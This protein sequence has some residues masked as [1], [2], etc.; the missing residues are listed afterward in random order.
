[1]APQQTTPACV[2]ID[3][4]L[5]A[6]AAP[7]LADLRLYRDGQETPYVIE[8]SAP[9]SAASEQAVQPLNI[10]SRGGQ[11][12]FDA[13]MPD[14]GYSDF[15][16]DVTG[17]DFIATVTVTG[18]QQ[19]NGPATRIGDY[20]IFDLTRQRLGR[21]TVLHLPA[22]DFRYLHFRIAGP[23]RP[24]NMTGLS[25]K[26]AAAGE[27]EYSLVA[28]TTRVTQKG[29]SS[30][31]EFTVPAHVPV[32]RVAVAAGPAPANFSRDT[33]IEG[34]PV[35]ASPSADSAEPPVAVSSFGNLLRVHTVQG[36]HRIDQEHLELDASQA[37]FDTPSHWTISIDNGDNPPLVPASVRLEM[38]K[39]D[40]CFEGTRGSYSLYYGDAKL[41][42][43]RY[44]LGQF[45]V[46][47]VKDAA[48]ATAGPEQANPEYQPRP[49]DRPFTE[50]HP[51]L[52]WLAL[53]L[54]IV[55]LGAIALRSAKP[56]SPDRQSQA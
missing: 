36:G 25:L 53:G 40:L 44:D 30:I 2:A 20:T 56:A 14:G 55:L 49:D 23:L 22:S 19:Q 43:P 13:A 46:V 39:R 16:L 27:P 31:I 34:R 51:A 54:V 29:H 5:F 26:M 47:R 15:T 48:Q 45:L 9:A 12:V 18:S 28:E 11:T 10:G 8:M 6:H 32:D 50:R 21:S 24:E 33:T 37:P 3:A 52:L 17:R 35:V 4:A 42:P 1:M 41:S 38:V 7:G